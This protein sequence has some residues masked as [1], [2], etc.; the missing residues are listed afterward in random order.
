MGVYTPTTITIG[1]D[2][3]WRQVEALLLLAAD[4]T[5]GVRREPAPAVL[6]VG[7]ED[8]YVRYTLL[9]AL[10]QPHR[11]GPILAT[12]HANIQDAFNEHGVQIMSPNYEADPETRKIVPRD[13]WFAAPAARR[14]ETDTVQSA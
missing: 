1:Y 13:Q 11:R 5:E 9:V 10:E 7:L 8:F 2:V 14:R 12:L 3:P 6:Q 4:R